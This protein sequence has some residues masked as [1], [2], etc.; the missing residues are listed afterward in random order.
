MLRDA[1]QRARVCRKTW[2]GLG[3]FGHGSAR[4]YAGSGSFGQ[5]DARGGPLRVHSA[6]FRN[7]GSGLGS[8]G[9]DRAQGLRLGFPCL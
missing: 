7:G 3:S 6:R 4:G 8:F 9:R 5:S 2:S 1:S